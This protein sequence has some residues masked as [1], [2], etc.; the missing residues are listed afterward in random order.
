M[1][2]CTRHED[3]LKLSKYGSAGV[4]KIAQLH[5]DHDFKRKYVRGFRYGYRNIDYLAMLTPASYRKRHA[6]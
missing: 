5:H 2:I 3:N 1:L 4:V 6:S